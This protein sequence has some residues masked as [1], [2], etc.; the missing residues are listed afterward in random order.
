MKSS[1]FWVLLVVVVLLITGLVFIKKPGITGMA[2]ETPS[3][4]P[5]PTS[6][7]EYSPNPSPIDS[8]SPSPTPTQIQCKD[9]DKGKDYYVSGQITYGNKTYKDHCDSKYPDILYEYYCL[10]NE[11][12]KERKNCSEI[13]ESMTCKNGICKKI[14]LLGEEREKI[15]PQKVTKKIE[16]RELKTQE[17]ILLP[18]MNFVSLMYKPESN[19]VQDLFGGKLEGEKSAATA[20]VIW[21]LE[22]GEGDYRYEMAWQVNLEDTTGEWKDFQDKFMNSNTGELSNM[23]LDVGEGFIIENKHKQ[24]IITIQGYEV[25]K[26][27]LDIKKGHNYIGVPF[28]GYTTKEVYEQFLQANNIHCEISTWQINRKERWPTYP[29][30]NFDILPGKAYLFDNCDE[31]ISLTIKKPE[32]ITP[33][34]SLKLKKQRSEEKNIEETIEEVSEEQTGKIKQEKI[35]TKIWKLIKKF[36]RID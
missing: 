23:Q 29:D 33:L 10:D 6:S 1:M 31:S 24:K 25:D 34:F 36:F 9:P 8:Q 22:A 17:I 4:S 16:A 32:K 27:P 26:V 20:D 21:K 2:S 28:K 5:T 7:P 35:G 11:V 19:S 3:P 18:G 13:E 14:E 12:K 30:M 15:E